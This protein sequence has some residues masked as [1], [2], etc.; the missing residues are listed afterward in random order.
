MNFANTIGP[1]PL[2][3]SA[4]ARVRSPRR[5]ATVAI[6]QEDGISGVQV[7]TLVLWM[8]LLTIGGFGFALPYLRP[9]A[10]KPEPPPVQAQ[11]LAVQL[12]TDDLPDL[13]PSASEPLQSPVPPAAILQPSAVQ[14]MLVA[15]PSPT[16]AFALPVS[17]PA[18]VVPA[19]QASYSKAVSETVDQPVTAVQTL[20]FG[21]GEGKQPAPEYPLLARREGQEGSV[22]VRLSVGTDGRVTHA[23]AAES[24]PWPLLNDSA[25]RTIS[26]RWRF[27]PGSARLYEVVIHFKLS[28]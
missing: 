3:A 6:P 24:C 18:Q 2:L 27:A 1:E 19:A 20:T 13:A 4:E 10:P 12:T 26:K 21:R 14:P 28:R 9:A 16:I 5:V 22:R 15:E 23:E 17:A 25:L 8:G 11:F 7:F